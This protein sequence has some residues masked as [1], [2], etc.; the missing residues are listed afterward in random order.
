MWGNVLIAVGAILP[1]IGGSFARGGVVE[2]LYAT[3]LIGLILI[4]I[5]YWVMVNDRS[6][7]LHEAQRVTSETS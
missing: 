5:G 7:S 1:G 6:A 3:E 2:V 4:W